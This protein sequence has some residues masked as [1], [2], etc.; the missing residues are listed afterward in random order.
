MTVIN[1][2]GLRI[3][4]L[5]TSEVIGEKDRVGYIQIWYAGGS[6]NFKGIQISNEK[7]NKLEY[8]QFLGGVQG[9]Q[10]GDKPFYGMA[11]QE[12]FYDGLSY[13]LEGVLMTYSER[14]KF[15]GEEKP[16]SKFS[17]FRVSEAMPEQIVS[18]VSDD[19]NALISLASGLKF[20]LEE[21]AVA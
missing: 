3:L 20:P 10:L 21:T 2:M 6:P 16:D 5:N 1:V 9:I 12:K 15:F 14:R 8:I 4:D 19:K 17:R 13:L 18:F 7:T 11:C